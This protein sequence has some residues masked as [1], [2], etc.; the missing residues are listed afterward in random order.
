MKS[1]HD[2]AELS[3]YLDGELAPAE[4]AQVEQRLA[5]DPAARKA[6]Q[7]LERTQT[8]IATTMEDV[9]FTATVQKRVQA[10]ETPGST[11]SRSFVIPAVAVAVVLVAVFTGLSWLGG[12][13]QPEPDQ[14]PPVA[15]TPEAGPPPTPVDTAEQVEAPAAPPTPEPVETLPEVARADAPPVEAFYELPEARV[16]YTLLAVDDARSPIRAY[17]RQ[18]RADEVLAVHENETLPDDKTLGWAGSEGIILGA[19]GEWRRLDMP[20]ETRDDLTGIWRV[21]VW[22]AGELALSADSVEISEGPNGQFR[23]PM[24]P[25]AGT[26]A[27]TRTGERLEVE[28]DRPA[29]GGASMT[30]SVSRELDTFDMA[31]TVMTGNG[32]DELMP[33]ALRGERLTPLEVAQLGYTETLREQ[34]RD[35][36]RDTRQALVA[37]HN[38]ED[39]LPRDSGE[40]P[41]A[42]SERSESARLQLEESL[43]WY[44]PIT[45]N[46][47]PYEHLPDDLADDPDRLYQFEQ[48]IVARYGMEA[49]L[50]TPILEM[51][52]EEIGER[53]G[54]ALNPFG[55]L[56]ADAV[57]VWSREQRDP[58][59][60]A[61]W[62][63]IREESHNN[64]RQ[65]GIVF[66]MFANEHQDL[67]PPG[68]WSIYP[69]YLVDLGVLTHPLDEPGTLS[70]DYFLPAVDIRQMLADMQ[71]AVED[72]DAFPEREIQEL[73]AQV[74]LAAESRPHGQPAGRIILFADGHTEWFPEPDYQRLMGEWFR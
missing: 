14:P 25:V 30:G 68:W 15:E 10:M 37:F 12:E 70:Y 26:L 64:L 8:L 4:R 33:V 23:I 59:T 19:P 13:E 57:S 69:E 38:R 5:S 34:A 53:H 2:W 22:L 66:R 71:G 74:P 41:E 21:D 11:D 24:G 61:D 54:L 47:G 9:D 27:G 29:A 36:M 52:V 67:T 73:M 16:P 50:P 31:G 40:L 63:A 56:L 7:T 48:E 35:L 44:E 62:A 45:P 72:E 6:L 46:L 39:R 43:I 18:T 60:E 49:P 58:R 32:D 55:L 3:A 28:N 1:E 65:L 17:I 20:V 42:L 51:E